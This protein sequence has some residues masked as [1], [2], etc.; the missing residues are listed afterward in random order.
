MEGQRLSSDENGVKSSKG[1]VKK[2]FSILPSP[3][4]L[5]TIIV[6]GAHC[7]RHISIAT[8]DRINVHKYCDELLQIDHDGKILQ[9]IS[10]SFT[11]GGFHDTTEKGDLLFV[12]QDGYNIKK[13]SNGETI[14]LFTTDWKPYC[15]HYS[16]INGD[17]LLVQ[18]FLTPK[19]KYLSKVTRHD[20]T[21]WTQVIKVNQR[22]RRLYENRPSF[23]T[24]NR[25]GDIWTSAYGGQ[26]VVVNSSGHHRF[27]YTGQTFQ[28]HF[29]PSGICTDS[30]GHALV[31]NCWSNDACASIH[32]L[33]QD[34]QFLRL[35]M[36]SDDGLLRPSALCIDDKHNLYLG[37]ENN[38]I[39]T[40]Y[41]YLQVSGN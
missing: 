22:G 2:T 3:I 27:N 4:Q 21:G 8:S 20:S 30:F 6:P 14:T 17:I 12:D 16:R 18:H 41:K 26:V 33:D 5:S 10:I 7:V 35:L 19:V 34:G 28:S 11:H 40:V 1:D 31:C 23:I 38:N 32:L 25:N 9:N 13:F 24:E 29:R 15:I 37:Q 36:T 39:I